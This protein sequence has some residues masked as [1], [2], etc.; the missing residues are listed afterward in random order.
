MG[1]W[2]IGECTDLDAADTDDAHGGSG[3]RRSVARI[4]AAHSEKRSDIAFPMYHA[5]DLDLALYSAI[6][7]EVV[8]DRPVPA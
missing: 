4:R 3:L 8:A 2:D 1:R 6:D 7:Y 5:D